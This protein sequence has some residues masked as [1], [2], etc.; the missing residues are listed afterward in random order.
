MFRWRGVLV[1]AAVAASAVVSVAGPAAA[2]SGRATDR[3]QPSTLQDLDTAMRGEAYA[4]TRYRAF[5][6]QARV[7]RHPLVGLLFDRTARTELFDHFATEARFAGLVRGDADNLRDAIA[8]ERYESSI[9]YPAF[10]AQARSQGD[11]AAAD[12]FDE[13][14]SDEASHLANFEAALA[15]VLNPGSGTI[16]PGPSVTPVPIQAGPP[17]SSGATLANEVTTAQGES[18]AFAKYTVYGYAALRHGNLALARLF[19]RTARVEREEHFAEMATLAGLVRD[20]RTNLRTAIAGENYE[21]TVMYPR[22]AARAAAV[23][24]LAV[25]RAFTE[26]ARDERHHAQAFR[27]ALFLLGVVGRGGRSS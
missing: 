18:F 3:V 11:T 20:T 22:F 26:I 12:R 5:A 10:A 6:A 15:V 25:A 16:P 23:G 13:L 8:G 9:L 14:A 1:A 21:G 27:R 2:D 7:E 19:F 17:R 24:D 4:Y